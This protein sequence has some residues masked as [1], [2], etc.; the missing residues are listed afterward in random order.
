M[1]DTMR[2]NI[3]NNETY[4]NQA[5][6]EAAE[7]I[8]QGQ[9]VAFPTETVYGLGADATNEAAVAK[10]FKAKGRPQDNPLIAHVA[11]VDQLRRLVDNLPVYTEKLIKAFSPGPITYVLPSNGACAQNVTAGLS[12]IGVRIPDHPVAQALLKKA[13]V[14][15]AAP[16]ANL[17]GKP[18]PTMGNHVWDDLNGKISGLLDGGPTGVGLESTVIDCTQDI[19]IILRPG[20]IT[21]EQLEAVVHPVMMD[22]GLANTKEKPKSPGMKYKHYSPEVPLWLVEGTHASIQAIVDQEKFNGNRVGVLASQQTAKQI[23]A[24]EIISLGENINEI[25]IHLYEGLRRFKQGDVDIIICEVFTEAGI[26]QAVMNRLRK[27]ASEYI[28][29]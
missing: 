6:D 14:P 12:T 23:N 5:I 21:K 10:I 20:G 2:W 1:I 17:S 13:D 15:V 25:A 19:P 3:K 26:G 7:L 4:N 22:P 16:S 24:E 28:V 18:S 9:A 29:K 27:A 8:K 11:T